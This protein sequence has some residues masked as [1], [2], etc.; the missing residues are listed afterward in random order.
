MRVAVR[1][2]ASSGWVDHKNELH[3]WFVRKTEEPIE[4][5]GDSLGGVVRS[6]VAASVRTKA[7]LDPELMD[8]MSEVESS[9]IDR[10]RRREEADITTGVRYAVFPLCSIIVTS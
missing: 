6:I 10:Y 9:L 7:E 8:R 4:V 3:L 5:V 2:E 1:R